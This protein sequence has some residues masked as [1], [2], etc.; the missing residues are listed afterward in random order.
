MPEMKYRTKNVDS[1][2]GKRRVYFTCHPGDFEKYFDKIC[3]DVFKTHDVAIYYTKDMTAPFAPEELDTDLGS[4]NLFVVPVTHRLLSQPNRAMDSDISYAKQASIPILPFMMEPGIDDIYSRPEKFGSLQYLSPFSQEA[5]QISYADKLK[6]YLDAVIV[7]DETVKRIQAAFDAYIFLSYRKKDRRYANELMRLIHSRPEYRDIA[8]WYDEFLTPGESFTENITHALHNSQVF[9]LLVTPSLLEEG[10]FVMC[11]EYPMAQKECKPILPVEME[12]TNRFQLAVRFADIPV[13]VDS[14]DEPLLRDRLAALLSRIARRE[15][16]NDPEHNFLI[17]LAY[18]DGIDVEVNRERGLALITSAA[19]AGLP[20][21]ME[22]LYQIS[23]ELLTYDGAAAIKWAGKLVDHYQAEHGLKYHKTRTWMTHLASAHLC[24]GFYKKALE[25]DTQV[26][27]MRCEELGAFHRAT[28]YSL[29]RISIDYRSMGEEKKALEIEEELIIARSASLGEVHPDLLEQLDL[30]AYTYRQRGNHKR[31]LEIYQKYYDL[32]CK[33]DRK[34]AVTYLY[35]LIDYYDRAGRYTEA[36]KLA[37]KYFSLS[38]TAYGKKSK[39]T[40]NSLWALVNAYERVGK[41]KKALKVLDMIYSVGKKMLKAMTKEELIGYACPLDSLIG[42]YSSINQHRRAINLAK[43]M[44]SYRCKAEGENHYDSLSAMKNLADA[45]RAAGNNIEAK[46]V[47][48]RIYF[49]LRKI[50]DTQFDQAMELVLQILSDRYQALGEF[51]RVLDVRKKIYEHMCA[52]GEKPFEVQYALVELASAYYQVNMQ[53]EAMSLLKK[54]YANGKK[55]LEE[56]SRAT[57]SVCHGVPNSFRDIAAVY[58]KMKL[59]EPARALYEE[60]YQ[61]LCEIYEESDSDILKTMSGLAMAHNNLGN[62][63]EALKL[64]EKVYALQCKTR[65]E[66]HLDAYTTLQA[67][68]YTYSL[69]GEHEKALQLYE[70]AYEG[71]LAA[72][73]PLAAQVKEA[74]GILRYQLDCP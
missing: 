4:S 31:A 41:H 64:Y 72:Q 71:L 46:K 37:K 52:K 51:E 12:Q 34:N 56:D 10:N 3:Q 32:K 1:P 55:M 60:A 74:I 8:I 45:Y 30:L 18:L 49:I 42:R 67:I 48:D 50:P 15:N 20:E 47:C 6:K 2:R 11:W 28:L 16:D 13:C 9:A 62:Y 39:E 70:Q 19:E 44:Y 26:Y 22:K 66:D 35:E 38:V 36:L 59:Y 69:L 43:Y 53:E 29:E 27:Q 7:S 21:A 57:L 73:S 23:S 33:Q 68:A 25:L 63:T 54:A 40:V 24:S 58:E 14:H 17:G 61:I 65:G 5:T